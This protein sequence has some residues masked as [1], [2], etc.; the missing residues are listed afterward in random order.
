MYVG[1]LVTVEE[2]AVESGWW[3]IVAKVSQCEDTEKTC[4]KLDKMLS[5]TL[6]KL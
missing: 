1:M 2:H 4:E 3:T 5:M 6:L